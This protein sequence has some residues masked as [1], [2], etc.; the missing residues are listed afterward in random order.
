MNPASTYIINNELTECMQQ[1]AV[2]RKQLTIVQ[3]E[4]TRLLNENRS[5]RNQRDRA[6]EQD[7]CTLCGTELNSIA[8]YEK[9]QLER[10]K[11]NN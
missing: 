3:N 8:E 7:Y 2:S 10:L 5:L 4:C 11:L 9:E 6:I 1:L